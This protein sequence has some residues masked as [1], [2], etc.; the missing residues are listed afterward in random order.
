MFI[1]TLV[2]FKI[3]K[4]IYVIFFLIFTIILFIIEKIKLNSSN[5]IYI[6]LNKQTL[7]TL[8][9]TGNKCSY[10][11][12]PITFLKKTLYSDEFIKIGEMLTKCINEEVL[13]DIYIGPLIMINQQYKITY[14]AFV[15]ISTYDCII[16]EE[17][18]G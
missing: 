17:L 8:I 14:Y 12:I 1:G 7:K 4:L 15:D 5:V 11:N 6:T 2:V 18:G 3:D 10:Q 16:G 9:D 13:V